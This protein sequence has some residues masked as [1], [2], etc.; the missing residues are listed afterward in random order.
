MATALDVGG[1]YWFLDS[2]RLRGW[3]KV[4]S[5]KEE[6]KRG[7][8]DERGDKHCSSMA[9]SDDWTK[10]TKIKL[11]TTLI[12]IYYVSFFKKTQTVKKNLSVKKNLLD[13]IDENLPKQEKMNC[14][15]KILVDNEYRKETHLYTEKKVC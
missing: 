1:I 5:Q 10:S 13:T 4:T 12:T 14:L 3:G 9:D 15:N 8:G 2:G 6:R 7:L 11:F